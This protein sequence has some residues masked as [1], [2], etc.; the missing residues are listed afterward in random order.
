M[1]TKQAVATVAVTTVQSLMNSTH[2][3]ISDFEFVEVLL[4][5]HKCSAFGLQQIAA[6]DQQT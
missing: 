5:P 6:A 1:C 3:T 2:L 4:I